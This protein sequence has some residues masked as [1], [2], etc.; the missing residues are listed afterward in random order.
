MRVRKVR[1]KERKEGPSS[2]FYNG[3]GYLAVAG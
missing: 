2:P 3:L 1:A